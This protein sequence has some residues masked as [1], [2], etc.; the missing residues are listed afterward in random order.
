[1]M[2]K[3]HRLKTAVRTEKE[4]TEALDLSVSASRDGN[5]TVVSLV[6]PRTSTDV[7]AD[8]SFTGA[9]PTSASAQILHNADMNA[10]NSFD[11][12]D[13]ITIKPH[14]VAIENGRMRVDIPAMSIVTVTLK[15]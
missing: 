7:Q 12:P 15:A 13:K 10:F 2:F 3:P 6:N 9:A 11:D 5:E 1:M 4:S 8:C 14:T